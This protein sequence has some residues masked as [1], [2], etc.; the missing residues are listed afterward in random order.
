MRKILVYMVG[1]GFATWVILGVLL[2]AAL[3]G[4]MPKREL[5]HLFRMYWLSCAIAAAMGAWLGWRRSS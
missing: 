4:N 3:W 5:D 2:P 1:W